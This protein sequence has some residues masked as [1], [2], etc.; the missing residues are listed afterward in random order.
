LRDGFQ[1][2]DAKS[3]DTFANLSIF[4]QRLAQEDERSVFAWNPI[5]EEEIFEVRPVAHNEVQ[6]LELAPLNVEVSRNA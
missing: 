4:T 2:S 1:I 5:K 6:R 3:D